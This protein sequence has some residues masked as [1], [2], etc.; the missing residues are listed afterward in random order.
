MFDIYVC[1]IKLIMTEIRRDALFEIFLLLKTYNVE[2]LCN[3]CFNYLN[4]IHINVDLVN[5]SKY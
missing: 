4:V 1:I 5:C 3:S 2:M